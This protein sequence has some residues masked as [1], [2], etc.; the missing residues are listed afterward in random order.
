[1]TDVDRPQ[2]RALEF[3]GKTARRRTT[4]RTTVRPHGLQRRHAQRQST[5]SVT[6]EGAAEGLVVLTLVVPFEGPQS[7]RLVQGC[8]HLL[9]LLVPPRII[10]SLTAISR[11]S[12]GGRRGG[13]LWST[14]SDGQLDARLTAVSTAPIGC[15]SDEGVGCRSNQYH[16][17]DQ[18]QDRTK[19]PGGKT[20]RAAQVSSEGRVRSITG[21]V[22][23]GHE[24]KYSRYCSAQI[25]GR[26]Y[27]V[28]RLVCR[29]FNGEP[30][31]SAHTMVNHKDGVKT[32]NTPTNLE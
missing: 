4:A 24:E 29:T 14:I 20:K 32:N 17:H 21:V 30:P 10:V 12:Q 18:G 1:M 28:H 5:V 22:G 6:N 13:R 27:R 2:Y 26:S 25:D 3:K 7:M 15:P 19:Q 16:S 31:T 8:L 9:L 11:I 23:Y